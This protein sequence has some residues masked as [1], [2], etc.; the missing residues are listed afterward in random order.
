MNNI[1]GACTN[2]FSA[3]TYFTL[4]GNSNSFRLQYYQLATYLQF[5]VSLPLSEIKL[6]I[7]LCCMTKA[8]ND[9]SGISGVV[10]IAVKVL[11]SAM[12]AFLN[13][14]LRTPDSSICKLFQRNSVKVWRS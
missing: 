8:C 5:Y 12:I 7:V 1:I 9:C 11:P 3:K 10:L 4:F 6:I 2:I 13:W 14:D